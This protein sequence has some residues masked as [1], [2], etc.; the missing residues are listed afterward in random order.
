MP[1]AEIAGL[2]VVRVVGRQA[3]RFASAD[4]LRPDVEVARLVAVAGKGQQVAVARE[5][6]I[7]VEPA[8]IGD[9][10]QHR[11][12]QPGPSAGRSHHH[13]APAASS[14]AHD[15]QR[16]DP[17][18]RDTARC[19]RRGKIEIRQGRGQQQLHVV[20]GLPAIL[21][22][23][24]A[25]SASTMRSSAGGKSGG[26]LPGGRGLLGNHRRQRGQIGIF[27]KGAAPRNHFVE[28]AAEGEDIANANPHLC[29]PPVRATCRPRCR[30]R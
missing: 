21:A 19:R 23:L 14:A 16:H 7:I 5:R 1:S 12:R 3:N 6:R 8:R 18:S 20:H 15:R 11:N 2:A 4:L 10:A 9:L 27:V 22:F 26:E 30:R 13:V 28:H 25:G 24:A 29:P 17:A